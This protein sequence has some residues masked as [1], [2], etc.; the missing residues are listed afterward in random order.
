MLNFHLPYSVGRVYLPM[1][2]YT[3]PGKFWKF[4][5]L[6]KY[7]NCFQY[8]HNFHNSGL[9]LISLTSLPTFAV[10]ERQKFLYGRNVRGTISGGGVRANLHSLRIKY[11]R[12]NM[13]F[14]AH[15]SSYSVDPTKISQQNPCSDPDWT[16]IFRLRIAKILNVKR[17]KWFSQVWK[18]QKFEK[19]KSQCETW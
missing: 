16:L 5:K 8:F 4:C 18:I 14:W 1:G 13:A 19:W 6:W 17:A 2:I 12:G 10:W 7:E 11:S 9:T 3:A 15:K